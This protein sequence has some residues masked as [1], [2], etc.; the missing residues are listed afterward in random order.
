VK[1]R[2]DNRI[3]AIV[4]LCFIAAVM[5]LAAGCAARRPAGE[6]AERSKAH[7]AGVAYTELVELPKLSAEPTP[8]EYLR[9]AF[10]ANADLQ[11][12]YWQWR[13]AI[14]RIPQDTSFP[15]IA[16]PF[17]ILFGGGSMKLWDR[18]TVGLTN[19]PMTNITHPKK[20][21]TAGERDLEDARAA[22]ER[23]L[24]AK[25]E[26][27]GKVL[28][29]YY[30]LALLGEEIRIQDESNA[31]LDAV[32]RQAIAGAATGGTPQ[33]DLLKAEAELDIARNNRDNLKARAAPLQARMN[34]LLGRGAAEPV[35]L[36]ASVPEAREVPVADEALIRAGAAR[37]AQLAALD[38]DIKGR[39]QALKLAEEAYLP[40]FALS[41]SIS[42]AAGNLGGMVIL[43]TR[44]EAITA[45][46][47]QAHADIASA[48]AARTQYELDLAA[49]FVL[50]LSILRNDERQR[51]FF[52]N[53]VIPRARE[54][55]QLAQA[56]YTTGRGR[57][58]D[59]LDA[60]RTL[61]DTRL[62]VAQLRVEREKAL[63]AIETWSTVDVETLRP[64]AVSF[65]AAATGA[66]AGGATAGGM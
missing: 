65:R 43:P 64:G 46:I 47:A 28:S 44:R 37:S 39:E 40:D 22:G 48:Q 58:S 11:Q 31:L 13:S 25:F 16:V 45:A 35:A 7:A 8:D 5:L 53:T 6:G 61:L 4:A 52:E 60:Q 2:R 10:L 42:G 30:D 14:E 56:S 54:A 26:L 9:Y 18:L 29:S 38:R 63:A 50:N 33:Q 32:M 55:V 62:V 27:Q 59:V 49:S 17:S 34:A 20:L 21:E 51:E 12:R 41:T 57:F 66:A 24:E 19:D 15:N 36:P 23:F 1:R 3:C